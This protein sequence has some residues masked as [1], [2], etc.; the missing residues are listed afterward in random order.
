MSYRLEGQNV[1]LYDATQRLGQSFTPAAT[2]AGAHVIAHETDS[3]ILPAPYMDE[4]D[5]EAFFDQALYDLPQLDALVHHIALPCVDQPPLLADISLAAWNCVLEE[6]LRFPFL[7]ARRAINEFLAS[8]T[9]GRILHIVSTAGP[10]A[11]TPLGH[12][13]VLTALR[14]LARSITKEY[15]ARG[16]A[17]NQIIYRPCVRSTNER[18]GTSRTDHRYV[19]VGSSANA[20]VIDL[21]IF[22]LSESASFVNGEVLDLSVRPGGATS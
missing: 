13:A 10:G 8:G 2:A 20:E 22:L 4:A 18:P 14:A 5:V 21:A 11:P 9:G 6:H 12:T 3:T 17:C 15:G 19:D 16:V 7:L 1:I